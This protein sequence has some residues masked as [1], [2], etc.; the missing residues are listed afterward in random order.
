MKQHVRKRNALH[1]A[2]RLHHIPDHHRF[3]T[4]EVVFY[5]MIRTTGTRIHFPRLFLFLLREVSVICI[6]FIQ[7]LIG[8]QDEDSYQKSGRALLR[9]VWHKTKR[10]RRR[11]LPSWSV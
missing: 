5:K 10:P 9:G 2:L 11:S 4:V 6:G 7:R 8:V 1:L 3:I